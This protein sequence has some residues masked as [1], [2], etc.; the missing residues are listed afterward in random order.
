MMSWSCRG[1]AF[2][3]QWM[4]RLENRGAVL[5]AGGFRHVRPLRTRLEIEL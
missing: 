2:G 5:G 3:G 1:V 4:L